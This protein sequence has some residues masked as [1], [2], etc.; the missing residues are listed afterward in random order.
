MNWIVLIASYI[1]GFVSAGIIAVVLWRRFGYRHIYV[2]RVSPQ[3][4]RS[5]VD[6]Q[7]FV[8][9]LMISGS[10]RDELYVRV[11]NPRL[12]V[13]IRK[14]E[15]KRQADALVI[16]VRNSDANAEHYGRIKEAFDQSNIEYQERFTPRQ[17]KPKDLQ[18][19]I[20]VGT[21]APAAVGAA[22]RAIVDATK[23]DANLGMLV[24]PSDPVYWKNGA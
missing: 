16:E 22:L 7:P 21:Y 20:E 23:T 15:Y 9:S 2:P 6:L 14:R 12:L 18:V 24:S 1:A 8:K 4:I 3:R 11:D 10:D 17:H 19:R 5:V 13:R